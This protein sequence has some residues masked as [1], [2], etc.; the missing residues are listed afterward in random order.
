MEKIIFETSVISG[1]VIKN[2]SI[3]KGERWP[4]YFFLENLREDW[5]SLANLAKELLKALTK[6]DGLLIVSLLTVIAMG[7]VWL[8]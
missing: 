2:D 3:L 4:K 8:K 5:I 6:A 7:K 1:E